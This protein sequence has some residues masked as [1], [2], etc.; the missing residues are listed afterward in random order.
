VEQ[1]N[2][3]K[4][5]LT[6]LYDKGLLSGRYEHGHMYYNLAKV[7]GANDGAVNPELLA[8]GLD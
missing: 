2:S 8:P 1:L 7:T 3:V 4:H 5:V 6:D